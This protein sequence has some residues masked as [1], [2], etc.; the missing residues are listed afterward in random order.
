MSSRGAAPRGSGATQLTGRAAKTSYNIL[1]LPFTPPSA[2]LLPFLVLLDA[3]PSISSSGMYVRRRSAPRI[4]FA[5]CVEVSIILRR[6]LRRGIIPSS[7]QD[8]CSW[9]C[10]QE[11]VSL[12]LPRVPQA[13]HL[14]R[15]ASSHHLCFQ[16][17]HT[18]CTRK[19][20]P[21]AGPH[22]CVTPPYP[23]CHQSSAASHLQSRPSSM[24]TSSSKKSPPK[25]SRGRTVVDTVRSGVLAAAVPAPA[26]AAAAEAC[27]E[28]RPLSFTAAAALVVAPP[29]PA[30][31][32]AIC[33]LSSTLT[34]SCS[35]PLT[36]RVSG[37]SPFVA[38][39]CAMAV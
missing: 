13:P 12:L 6:L 35:S 20:A 3:A 24:P 31:H 5:A 2:L 37:H 30:I 15:A 22:C 26:G 39:H 1:L 11:A 21:A 33:A 27:P 25:L 19:A 8:G 32:A 10:C 7:C 23:R 9:L 14:L 28:L 18:R 36:C 4:C 16:L 17:V 29:P 34:S 38:S